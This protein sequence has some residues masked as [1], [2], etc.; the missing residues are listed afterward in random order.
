LFRSQVI[1]GVFPQT[2]H[3][4]VVTVNASIIRS[5]INDTE[6]YGDE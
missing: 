4:P 5:D 3:D 6:T 1:Y 2:S